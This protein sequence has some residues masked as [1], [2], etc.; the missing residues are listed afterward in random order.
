MYAH[1]NYNSAVLT[2]AQ[3]LYPS[4]T[5]PDPNLASDLPPLTIRETMKLALIFC[6]FWFIANW[7]VN[8]SLNYTSVA[9][10]TILSSMSG[11]CP[12]C[13]F[14]TLYGSP[15]LISLDKGSSRWGLVAC[16]AWNY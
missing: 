5:F 10:A 7:S 9:S 8:A 4:T 11:E 16:F 1:F 3:D 6:F 14:L 15:I 2:F 13:L 12:F